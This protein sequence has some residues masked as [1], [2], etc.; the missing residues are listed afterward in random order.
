VSFS[1]SYDKTD[2]LALWQDCSMRLAGEVA[3][4]VCGGTRSYDPDTHDEKRVREDIDL[5][6]RLPDKRSPWGRSLM[7]A[8]PTA[9][10]VFREC[11]WHAAD[12]VVTRAYV[13]RHLRQALVEDEDGVMNAEE[14]QRFFMRVKRD[15]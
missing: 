5:I 8:N 1:E 11:L 10:E 6:L 2:R 4:A 7:S 12:E 14:V 9:R 3:E 13:L 15:K